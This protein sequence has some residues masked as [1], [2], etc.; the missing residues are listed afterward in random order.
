MRLSGGRSATAVAAALC[1]TP[2][3]VRCPGSA[4]FRPAG[5]RPVTR[6]RC[7]SPHELQHT[8]VL[9]WH[10]N[11]SCTRRPLKVAAAAAAATAAAASNGGSS[12]S[13]GGG[14]WASLASLANALTNFFP[15]FVLGAAALGLAQPVAY[16]F[17]SPAAITPSLAITMLGMGLTLTFEDFKRVLTTPGRIFAGFALQYTIMPAAAYA[18]SRLAGL[19]LAFTIGLCIVG[20]CPGGTASNVVTYLAKADVTLSV[21]MTTASTLGAV[22][23]TPLLTQALLGTLVPVDAMALL[24]ST[25]QVVLLPVVLGAAI[26]SAFPKQVAALAPL[27]ALSAVVL[28]AL[29]CGRV[30]AENAAA[31]LQAGPQLLTSVFALHACGF[32]FGYALSRALGIPERAARTNSIEV[33]MQN[34]ALGAVLATAHFPAHPLAAVPCAISACMHSVMGS[35]LAAFWRR[36]PAG[37]DEGGSEA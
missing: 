2:P 32:F 29:I 25:L 27:S 15:M 12:S 21:A 36:Q 37:G 33:G 19:P 23:F 30:M 13:T 26:N 14:L 7:S 24:V 1:R 16:D 11:W 31:V 8:A 10:G 20:S 35:M 4:A 18:V 5:L 28:I 22:V 34:S 6:A 3:R 9:G 17:F